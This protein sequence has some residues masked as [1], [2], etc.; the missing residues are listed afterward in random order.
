MSLGEIKALTFDVFGTVADWRS[1]IISEGHA[2]GKQ[3]G[4]QVWTGLSLQ[5]LGERVTNRPCNAFAPATSPG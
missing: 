3:M 1:T 2:L 5:T 4:L